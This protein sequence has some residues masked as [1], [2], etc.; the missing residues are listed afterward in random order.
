[1][2]LHLL[3]TDNIE[4]L[5]QFIEYLSHGSSLWLCDRIKL[6]LTLVF[7]QTVTLG[8]IYWFIDFVM[9]VD[10]FI[11]VV[12]LKKYTGRLGKSWGNLV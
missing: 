9:T 1:M 3:K 10:T 11:I 2:W 12:I 6:R 5:F 8:W 4:Y 7:T